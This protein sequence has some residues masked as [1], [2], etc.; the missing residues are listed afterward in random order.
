MM[1]PKRQDVMTRITKDEVIAINSA[2][3]RVAKLL[4]ETLTY[5]LVVEMD[6][7]GPTHL[8][9]AKVV[10]KIEEAGWV[11]T[12]EKNENGDFTTSNYVI[13]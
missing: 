12:R 5:P 7:L 2:V 1:I 9:R 8:I 11:I 10:A 13:K 3:D 6:V 4:N